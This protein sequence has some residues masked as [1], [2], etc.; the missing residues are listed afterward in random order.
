MLTSKKKDMEREYFF[1][2]LLT[3]TYSRRLI[4]ACK[5]IQEKPT[6]IRIFDAPII[7]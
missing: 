4:N 5:C 3:E 2:L 6:T 1:Y 7:G